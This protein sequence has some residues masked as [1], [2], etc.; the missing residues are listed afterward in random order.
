MNCVESEEKKM[1]KYKMSFR[2]F[3]KDYEIEVY[4]CEESIKVIDEICDDV[5]LI[6]LESVEEV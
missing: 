5:G 1:K 6:E 2:S 3:G 4:I